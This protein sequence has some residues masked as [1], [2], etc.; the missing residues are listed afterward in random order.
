MGRKKKDTANTKEKMILIRVTQDMY[1]V[2]DS[3]AR[4]AHMSMSEYM[5]Q[6]AAN[7]HPIVHHEIVFNDPNLLKVFGNLGKI[8]S[9]LNQIARYLNQGVEPT[10][11]MFREVHRCISDLNK[12]RDQIDEMAGE[13]RGN[14]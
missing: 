14:C 3:N 8:G 4:A 6:L 11:E 13:Y 9:N 7:R 1:D 2:I 5:R 12:I 10:G